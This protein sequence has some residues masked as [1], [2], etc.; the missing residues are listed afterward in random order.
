[1]PEL[2]LK[3]SRRLKTVYIRNKDAIELISRYDIPG[4]LIYIDPPYPVSCRKRGLYKHEMND[5]QHLILISV[6]RSLK[7]AKVVVSGYWCEPYTSGL[8]EWKTVTKEAR[9]ESAAPR[10]EVL[11]MN[12][13]LDEV[14]I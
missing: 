1:M 3:V 4:S 12:Y 10:T 6:L 14:R 8:L 5:D 7:H 13:E 2:I 9:A 11:W